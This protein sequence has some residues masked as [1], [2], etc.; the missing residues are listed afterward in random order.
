MSDGSNGPVASQELLLFIER[1]ERL[2]EEKKGIA[3]DQKDVMAEAKSRGYDT[4]TIREII[5]LRKLDP[6]ERRERAALLDTYKASLGMLDGTPL[7]H[8]ALERLKKPSDPPATGDVANKA[9]DAPDELYPRAV[10]VVIFE[11]QSVG[12]L[13]TA[14][15]DHRLQS[16]C[17]AC[18]TDGTGGH[19]LRARLERR[20]RSPCRSSTRAART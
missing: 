6:H 2:D 19:G 12:V 13:L 14:H 5:K 9:N 17:C 20:A 15:V 7:G 3:D 4:K 16:R 10:E 11:P 18:R 8:W 1:W